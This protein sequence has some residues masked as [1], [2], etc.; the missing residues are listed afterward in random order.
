[1]LLLLL[2]TLIFVLPTFLDLSQLYTI[3]LVLYGLLLLVID[4]RLLGVTDIFPFVLLFLCLTDS[5]L[6]ALHCSCVLFVATF[7]KII[8]KL[9]HQII[10]GIL[11][12]RDIVFF[13]ERR[14][15]QSRAQTSRGHLF[16]FNRLV[17]W[18]VDISHSRRFFH[19]WRFF[20]WG[21]I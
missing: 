2:L 6:P 3:L 15:F 10:F 5:E 17:G 11:T 13:P 9:L 19:S 20:V 4:S 12:R 7:W 21:Y 1:M 14:I 16:L 8:G 18:R